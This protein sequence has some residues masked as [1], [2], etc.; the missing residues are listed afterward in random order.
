MV[1]LEK[2]RKLFTYKDGVFIRNYNINSRALKDTP[3]SKIGSGGYV[4]VNIDKKVYL[5]HRLVWFYH[6]GVWP[7]TIDH[8]DRNK[9]NNKIE[10]LRSVS[11]LYN[12]LNRSAH[13]DGKSK[14]KGV[15]KKPHMNKWRATIKVAGMHLHLGYFDTEIL[16][17]EIYKK[18]SMEWY[19]CYYN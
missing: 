15:S 1:T 13:V 16:A 14:Y 5:V 17:A 4:C 19:G 3:V 12:N 10:N 11:Q 7:D 8:I 6:Y 9:Q 2:L 18:T